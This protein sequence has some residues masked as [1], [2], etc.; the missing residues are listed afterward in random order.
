MKIEDFHSIIP[1]SG[2]AAADRG[3]RTNNSGWV[4]AFAGMTK[5]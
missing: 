1:D 2:E 5:L 3:S 4:P